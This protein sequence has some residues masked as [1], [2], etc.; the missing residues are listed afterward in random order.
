MMLQVEID[1]RFSALQVLEHPWVNVS[2]LRTEGF[3]L[4]LPFFNLSFVKPLKCLF[5][6]NT[7]R[8]WP[9]IGQYS[10][11]HFFAYILNNT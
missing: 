2:K 11:I 4:A 1:Q 3:I 10:T 8:Y 9:Q 7:F 6:M 5:G